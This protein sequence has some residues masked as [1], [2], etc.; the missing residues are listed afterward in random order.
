[1]FV[2]VLIFYNLIFNIQDSINLQ[3]VCYK[4]EMKRK[5]FIRGKHPVPSGHH[6][7]RREYKSKKNEKIEF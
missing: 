1:V 7:K 3:N 5:H 6:Y 4:L 2:K